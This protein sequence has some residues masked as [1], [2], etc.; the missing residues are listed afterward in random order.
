[1]RSSHASDVDIDIVRVEIA[2]ATAEIKVTYIVHLRNRVYE[3]V[4]GGGET[5]FSNETLGPQI[6]E[7]VEKM[8]AQIRIDLGL[9]SDDAQPIDSLTTTREEIE[10]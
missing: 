3:G 4:I 8:Q 2:P 5:Q 6:L 10:L 9:A 1:M 7:L